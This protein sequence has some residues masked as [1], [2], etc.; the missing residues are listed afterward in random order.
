MECYRHEVKAVDIFCVYYNTKTTSD[1]ETDFCYVTQWRK[2]I[3]FVKLKAVH[4][5]IIIIRGLDRVYIVTLPAF[6]SDL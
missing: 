3:E 6:D 1:T 2:M 4:H 5:S